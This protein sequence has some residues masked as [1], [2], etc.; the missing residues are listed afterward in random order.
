MF[1]NF[2]KLLFVADP[3]NQFIM[4]SNNSQV[5]DTMK[6][7]CF[8][9]TS[10]VAI[11]EDC[12]FLA[13]GYRNIMFEHCKREPNEAA[14]EIAR[15]CFDNRIECLWDDEPLSFFTSEAYKR[16]NCNLNSEQQVSDALFFLPGY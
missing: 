11:F 5:T 12:R 7:G 4:Q 6:D 9:A 14:H 16:C 8:S 3:A 15:F 10:S 1:A 2:K 13:A